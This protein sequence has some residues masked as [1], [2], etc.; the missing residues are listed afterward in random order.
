MNTIVRNATVR[1]VTGAAVPSARDVSVPN[2]TVAIHRSDPDAITGFDGHT[3]CRDELVEI[4]WQGVHLDR[5]RGVDLVEIRNQAG[6]LVEF[7]PIDPTRRPR[8][9]DGETVFFLVDTD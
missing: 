9:E 4:H 2:Q 7:L 8:E 3:A 6:R 1:L 5:L